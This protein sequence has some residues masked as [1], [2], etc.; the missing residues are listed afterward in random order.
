MECNYSIAEESDYKID[1]RVGQEKIIST[2]DELIKKIFENAS[3]N[4]KNSLNI[5]EEYLNKKLDAFELYLIRSIVARI[6]SY[7]ALKDNS[8][9]SKD[10]IDNV[11]ST[12]HT[13]HL[14]DYIQLKID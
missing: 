9:H 8:I 11:K 4:A 6:D 7:L 10:I 12:I 5:K 13:H 14:E 3:D 1:T 2:T